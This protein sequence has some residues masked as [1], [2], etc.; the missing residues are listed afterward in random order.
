MKT[1]SK[2]PKGYQNNPFFVATDGLDMLFK[3][4]QS[5]GIFLAIISVVM[6]FASMPNYFPQSEPATNAPAPTTDVAANPFQGIPV[7]LIVTIAIVAVL[8]ILFMMFLGLIISGVSDYT[9]AQLAKGKTVSLGEALKGFFSQFWGYTW[10]SIIVSVKVLLWALLFIVPGVVMAYRYSLSGV[11]F[12]EKGLRGN[13]AT[14]HSANITKGVWLTTFASQNLLNLVTLGLMQPML[15]PGTR[16]VLYR[17]FVSLKGDKPRAH[18]VAW[19]TLILPFLFTLAFIGII[20]LLVWSVANY[21]GS[22]N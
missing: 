7:E 19:L 18:F 21:A 8:F 9:S 20:A 4:A 2:L 22:M 12:F 3:K 1:T 14:K 16:A 11:S 10:I 5:V 13:A 17:Q 6:I 15:M